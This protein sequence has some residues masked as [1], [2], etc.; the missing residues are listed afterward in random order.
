M[1]LR[2]ELKNHYAIFV[3]AGC[4]LIIMLIAIAFKSCVLKIIPPSAPAM[5]E[6]KTIDSPVLKQV[7]R[8]RTEWE[9]L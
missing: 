5:P 6:F 1:S 8:Q 2:R 4:F 7:L 9:E 3:V